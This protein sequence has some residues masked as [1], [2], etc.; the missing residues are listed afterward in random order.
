MIK[1]ITE[2]TTVKEILELLAFIEK[3]EDSMVYL[4]IFDDFSGSFVKIVDKEEDAICDIDDLENY[5]KENVY[6]HFH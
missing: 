3:K 2:S 1:K 4:R 5:K 6:K